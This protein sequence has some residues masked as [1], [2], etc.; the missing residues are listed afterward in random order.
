MTTRNATKIL[1]ERYLNDF[2]LT[3]DL[4]ILVNKALDEIDV[5]PIDKLS[6]W[7]GYVQ[8]YIIFSKQS[9]VEIERDISRP[10]FHEA[11]AFE[12]IDIPESFSTETK[13]RKIK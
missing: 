4:T 7:L 12:G 8:A 6:R 10:L 3:D 2:H 5:Y 9:S 13:K 11:Y 1:F